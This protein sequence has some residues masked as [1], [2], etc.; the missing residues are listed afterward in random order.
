MKSEAIVNVPQTWILP[1]D[2][3]FVW[4][5]MATSQNAQLNIHNSIFDF[6][7]GFVLAGT[8]PGKTYIFLYRSVAGVWIIF[9]LSWLALIFNMAASIM[10]HV[11]DQTYPRFRKQE[12]AENMPS[13]KTEATSKIWKWTADS[14]IYNAS[15][16]FSETVLKY[17]KQYKTDFYLI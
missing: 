5:K 11:L 17:T 6:V 16:I 8:N 4:A 10:E 14:T 7:F 12:E 2:L 15:N 1:E 3:N 13:S 9:G